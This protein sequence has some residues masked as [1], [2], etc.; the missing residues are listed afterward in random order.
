MLSSQ[1]SLL[2]NAK[3]NFGTEGFIQHPYNL[4]VRLEPRPESPVTE[5]IS[6]MWL[7]PESCDLPAVS[8]RTARV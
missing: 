5:E 8:P 7:L 2:T 1:I 6:N 4:L 3:V